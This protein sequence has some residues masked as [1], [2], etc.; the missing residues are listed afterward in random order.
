MEITIPPVNLASI[1]P[2][3]I[4]SVWAMILLLV[5]LWTPENRKAATAYLTLVG[6]ALALVVT[7]GLWGQN[8]SGF[9]GMVQL[10]N[11]ALFLDIV[12][13]VVAAITVLISVNYLTLQNIQHGE[14]Y[15]LVLFSTTGMM[16]MASGTDLIV[17][18]IS[19]E[20]LSIPL[21]VLAGFARPKLDSEEAALKY[22]LLGA[23]AS[24]FL[25]Y[26]VALTYGATGT[27]NLAR[28]SAFIG[29]RGVVSDPMLFVGLGLMI[30]GFGFKIAMVPFHMWTPDVYEGAPT[31]VTAFMSV[32]AKGGGFAAF[33]RVFLFA[34]PALHEQWVPIVA[35]LAAL[36]MIL[37][38]V[39]AVAQQ[40]IKR[41]LAYSSIAHAGYILIG[42]AAGNDLGVSGALF[43]LLA[44][45]FTNLGA[46]AVIIALAREGH[47][48]LNIADY[49]GLSKRKP[50][51]AAAMAIFMLS[52]T[53]V[54]PT[55]GLV[56]KIYVFQ[57]AVQ[58]DLVWLA[59][60]GVLTSVIS[61]FFYL[62]IVVIMYMREPVVAPELNSGA[63][64]PRL[65][66]MMIVALLLA[67]LGTLLLGIIPAQFIQLAQ[68]SLLASM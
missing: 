64:L 13:I 21:Y 65:H 42:L 44:Y 2:P 46:F 11:Y 37:G 45:A 5:D 16:L 8:Q 25:I 34:F 66:P 52:L 61:A 1:A 40:N 60:I 31:S 19:L 14:Y 50:L 15:V 9:S 30:V 63:S 33:L 62:R 24:A 41:M 26:G 59:V 12:F 27:T 48:T 20:V 29:E 58:A 17:L 22:F 55:A 53:G 23:F 39:V 28:I 68:Q 4:L 18:V 43:Y 47:E 10:D 56:G 67:V 7:V 51:L 38:N 36:T 35:L 57:A 6:L 49:A 32:G 3:L 54:P